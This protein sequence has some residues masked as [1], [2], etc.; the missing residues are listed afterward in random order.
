MSASKKRTIRSVENGS[1][2]TPK[3]FLA[4]GI[5]CGIKNP[6]DKKKKDLSVIRSSKPCTSAGTFTKN[7]IK[8]APVRLSQTHLQRG[9]PEA[10]IINSGNANVAN[11]DRGTADAL[12]MATQGAEALGL[13]PNAMLVC[14]T[15]IIGV[16][17]PMDRITPN[18]PKLAEAISRTGGPD[19]AEAIMT[20]DTT[21]KSVAVKVVDN[22][23][24]S[25]SIGG[26]AKGAGMI[27]PDMATMLAFITTDVSIDKK[28]LRAITRDAVD[29]SFNR[30]TVDGDMSTNDTVLLL[31]NGASNSVI[32]EGVVGDEDAELF[33][34]ALVGVMQELA[35]MLVADGERVTKLVEIQVKGAAT[36]RDARW[37]AEAVANSTLCKCSWNGN[38]PNWGRIIHAIGYAN[39][40]LTES[41]IG[42]SFGGVPACEGGVDA[43]TPIEQLEEVVTKGEFTIEIDL[44]LGEDTCTMWTSDLSPEYVDF[45]RTEYAQTRTKK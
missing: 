25:Y 38:D 28:R 37:V 42:I 17:M 35:R 6:K 8:A 44:G 40:R 11:G 43:G 29:M 33:E 5:A 10:I 24:K 19:A 39:A 34:E 13:Q 1:V 7:R 9:N 2:T 22:R 41:R 36:E 21:P 12:A 27:R 31:A 3:G 32:E 4:G 30:I 14:S 16:P 15:G 45:N 20:S 18:I 26:I 23:G